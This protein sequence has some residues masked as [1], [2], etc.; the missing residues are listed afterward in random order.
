MDAVGYLRVSTSR[1]RVVGMSLEAQQAAIAGDA[2]RRGWPLVAWFEEARSA[3]QRSSRRVELERAIA[4]ARE[5]EGALVI[6]RM[7]RA[8]RSNL[9][10]QQT[11]ARAH[12]EGWALVLLDPP[13]DLSTPYGKALADMAAAYAELSS[14][15]TSQRTREAIEARRL[16][17]IYR[18]GPRLPQCQ[19]TSG[20]A[21]Q[22]ILALA[23]RGDLSQ[24]AIA[25]RLDLE[26]VPTPH[27]AKRWSHTTV[28]AVLERERQSQACS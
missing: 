22:R 19:P 5:L 7:D 26:G 16:A 20:H 21:V 12:R 10:F 15:L 23:A 27:G 24:R 25:R 17:G 8:F 1:Q 9:H 18:G 11:I 6:A 2:G 3:W 28:G 14:A 13:V 4:A